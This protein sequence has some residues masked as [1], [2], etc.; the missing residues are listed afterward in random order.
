MESGNFVTLKPR[1][2]TA[3]DLKRLEIGHGTMRVQYDLDMNAPSQRFIFDCCRN[4]KVYETATTNV[5]TATLK[6]GDTFIDVGAHVGFFSLI[7]AALVGPQGRVI[8]FEPNTDN[9]ASLQRNVALNGF[10]NVTCMHAAVGDHEGDVEFFENLDN[11]GGHALWNPGLHPFNEMS[12][13]RRQSRR[14]PMTTLDSALSALGVIVIKAV[15]IDTEGAEV[16]VIKGGARCLAAA[17]LELLVCEDNEFGLTNLGA[18]EAQ[19]KKMLA[20]LG[21]S[22]CVPDK[23]GKFHPI[24][25]GAAI[26]SGRIENFYC[27]R[28]R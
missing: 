27:F 1:T 10:E 18:S 25:A 22:V 7:A 9:F 5:L 3:V 19:L 15:K 13:L 14:V 12:K 24:A 17:E 26:D 2:S 23:Q 16:Q 21:F 6:P 28:T 11:D 8:A 20:D 4:G